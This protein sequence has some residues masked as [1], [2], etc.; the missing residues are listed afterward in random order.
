MLDIVDG[1]AGKVG[2]DIS[3][4]KD[5]NVQDWGIE[6]RVNDGEVIPEAVDGTRGESAGG[7]ADS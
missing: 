4:I 3:G 2:E 5:S 1:C 7:A 6:G